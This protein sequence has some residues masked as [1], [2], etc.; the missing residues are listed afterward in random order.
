[1]GDDASDLIDNDSHCM[2][3]INANDLVGHTFLIDPREV[4]QCHAH[5]VKFIQDH[6]HDLKLSD[7]THKFRISINDDKY[8]EII[9]YNEFIVFIKKNKEN[10]DIVWKFKCIVG[11]QGPL[12]CIY[13]NYKGSKYNVL[14]EWENGEITEEPLAIIA[15]D[16]PV[17]CAIYAKEKGL[18]DKEE[19][20]FL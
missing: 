9:T 4:G 14:M 10:E 2:S 18:L 13:P 17:A 16:N 11:H 8:N 7:D 12:I 20:C 6:E 1:M 5:I 15:A 3:V 19:K